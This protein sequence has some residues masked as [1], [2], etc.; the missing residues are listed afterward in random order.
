MSPIVQMCH[1]ICENVVCMNSKDCQYLSVYIE[2]IEVTTLRVVHAL[3][4]AQTC[5]V[6]TGR[7]EGAR[8]LREVLVSAGEPGEPINLK[9]I[10]LSLTHGTSRMLH[11]P[12]GKLYRAR[13][14]NITTKVISP[15]SCQ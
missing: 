4:F 10:T 14:K 12:Y 1:I 5:L 8:L 13:C 7:L 11:M 2:T 3:W 9:R 15:C 6:V